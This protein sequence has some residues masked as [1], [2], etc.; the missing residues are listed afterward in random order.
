MQQLNTADQD[1]AD[2]GRVLAGD[3]DAFEA[4]VRRWQRPLINMAYRF[5]RDPGRAEDL[6]QDAF[7]QAFRRLGQWRQEAAFSTWLFALA[8]NVMRSHLRRHRPVEVPFEDTI[9][10][11]ADQTAA[12][13]ASADETVRRSV[14]AL[15]PK[16]R[17]AIVLFYFM[18]HDIAQ[19]ARILRVPEGT[20]KARLHRGRLLLKDRL[21]RRMGKP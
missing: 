18:E 19:A 6:A 8:L 16:Y 13:D 17:D 3:V 12:R 10:P 1:R 11:A 7:L 21:S 15:P 4:I 14:L 9:D 2:V 5:C 20:F